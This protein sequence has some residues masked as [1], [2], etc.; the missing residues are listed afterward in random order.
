MFAFAVDLLKL[1]YLLLGGFVSSGTQVIAVGAHNDDDSKTG[2]GVD[3]GA[4]YLLSLTANGT[5]LN[6][7]KISDTHGGINMQI[8]NSAALATSLA[9]IGDMDGDKVPD[10]AFGMP[11]LNSNTGGFL[12]LLLNEGGSVKR[13]TLVTIAGTSADDRVGESIAS[14]GDIDG[15]GVVDFAVGAPDDSSGDA[16]MGAVHVALMEHANI[17]GAAIRV[18]SSTKITSLTGMAAGDGFGTSIASLGA[19]DAVDTAVDIAVGSPFADDGGADAG[20]L[21]IVFLSASTPGTVRTHVRISA[22][23]N[24]GFTGLLKAGDHFGSGVA[25]LG[26]V[27]GDGVGDLAV[28][29]SGMNGGEGGVYIVFLRLNGTVTGQQLLSSSSSGGLASIVSLA[30]SFNLGASVAG[31]GDL[32]GDGFVDVAVGM[33]GANDAVLLLL[34]VDGTV[35]G[36][37]RLLTAYNNFTIGL[38]AGDMAGASVGLL[39]DTNGHALV[40]GAP[41]R[42]GGGM[43]RGAFFVLFFSE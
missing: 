16:A 31:V 1:T 34:S 33:P 10:C 29:A 30:A 22:T 28:G 24:T 41:G 27:N 15:N 18:L 36:G 43:D 3:R 11:G 19:F 9:P 42:D 39:G 12:V 38:D 8:I 25:L 26:D 20:A 14:V 37:R 6:E 40:V 23:S 13:E 5:V 7:Q 35:R 21:S 17:G 32:D 2:S 4:V